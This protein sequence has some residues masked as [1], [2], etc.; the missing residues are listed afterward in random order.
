M[1][2]VMEQNT[3]LSPIPICILK[4]TSSIMPKTNKA[5]PNAIDIFRY[6]VESTSF[7]IICDNIKNKP[8]RPKNIMSFP[9]DDPIKNKYVTGLIIGV[10]ISVT[11]INPANTIRINPAM[12]VLLSFINNNLSINTLNK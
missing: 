2:L 12:I 1:P 4:I 10:K 3:V 5:V 7:L 9:F 6:L 8:K 11:K